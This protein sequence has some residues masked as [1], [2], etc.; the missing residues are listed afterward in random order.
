MKNFEEYF[1]D[2]HCH[3]CLL[4]LEFFCANLMNVLSFNLRN[5]Q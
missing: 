2:F 3:V 4:F 5:L 1:L